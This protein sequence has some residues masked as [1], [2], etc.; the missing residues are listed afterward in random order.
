M[1]SMRN[2]IMN[3]IYLASL[4]VSASNHHESIK[5]LDESANTGNLFSTLEQHPLEKNIQINK[6][7]AVNQIL[8]HKPITPMFTSINRLFILFICCVF[9]LAQLQAQVNMFPE[10]N[11][12]VQETLK[13]NGQTIRFKE[14]KGQIHKKEVLYYFEGKEGSVYIEKNRIVFVAREYETIKKKFLEDQTYLKSTHTVSL[15]IYGANPEPILNLGE[16]FRTNYNYIVDAD[17]SKCFIGV[18]AAKDLTLEEL[19]PGIDL[20]LYSTHDGSLEFDWI[21][22]PGANYKNVKM[23]FQGQD[24]LSIENDG[25]LNVGL[26]FTNLKFHIPESYQVTEQGKVLVDFAFVKTSDNSISFETKSSINPAYP[27]VI[28]P[29][30]VWGTYMDGNEAQFDQY[31]YAIQLDTLDG[32]MYCAGATNREISTTAAPYD[33]NGWLNDISGSTWPSNAGFTADQTKVAIVYRINST[34]S[35]LLDL[36]LFSPATLPGNNSVRAHGLSLSQNRVFI[37]FRT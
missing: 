23:D 30:L 15:N 11:K 18:K 32:I 2:S 3:N 9:S 27:L 1:K 33:A 20:R 28:D 26:R 29:T 5:H 34:G 13:E 4:K 7:R 8:Q 17:P 14:N 25:S 22:D 10:M 37:G 31:L 19:Y 12:K 24:K 16:K 21:M 6:N 35:D 36:T